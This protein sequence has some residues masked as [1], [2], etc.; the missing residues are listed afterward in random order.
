M[1][2]WKWLILAVVIVMCIV[3][4][5]YRLLRQFIFLKDDYVTYTVERGPFVIRLTEEG[6]L[7]AIKSVTISAPRIRSR[8]QITELVDEG[9][10]M[11]EGDFILQLDNVELKKEVTDREADL[12]KIKADMEKKIADIE[13]SKVLSELN[14]LKAQNALKKQQ[15]EYEK[16]QFLS[17]SDRE[18]ARLD[19]EEMRYN[20][21]I[22]KKT[23]E[24]ELLGMETELKKLRLEV[25]QAEDELTL[26]R[27]ELEETT[28]RA[29]IPGMVVFAE[30]WKGGSWGKVQEGDTPWPGQALVTIPDLS[31]MLVETKI[32]EVDIDKVKI[33]QKSEIQLDAFPGPVFTGEI[34]KLGTLATRD[35]ETQQKVFEITV[36]LDEVDSR[37][38]PGMTASCDIILKEIPDTLYIPQ[39]AVWEDEGDVYVS[40]L[41]SGMAVEQRI[42]VGERNDEFIIVTSGLEEGDRIVLS[43]SRLGGKLLR[44]DAGEDEKKGRSRKNRTPKVRMKRRSK[45]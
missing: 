20:L 41:N 26:A 30:T 9:T 27:N 33:G 19:L 4:G 10:V 29:P 23:H 5:G 14:V 39:I 16:A 2:R 45:G 25:Q 13:L 11:E 34:T 12:D 42:E 3:A 28:L 44:K 21:E 32:N 36:T 43:E 22:E 6:E 38:R 35:Q 37:M 18:K 31:Q 8:L 1:G 40:K 24:T 7:K 15:Y 17:E